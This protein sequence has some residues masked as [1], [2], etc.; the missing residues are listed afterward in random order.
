VA[1]GKAIEIIMTENKNNSLSEKWPTERSRVRATQ[2]AFDASEAMDICI[3]KAA[4]ER[5]ISPSDVIREIIGLKVNK[6]V[7]RKRLT[8]SLSEDDYQLL[9]KKYALNRVNKSLVK[10][11]VY[12]ELQDYAELKS[13][14][15][16]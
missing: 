12:E 7:K 11:L 14:I 13:N 9:A 10:Q 5:G 3:R 6:G 1:S 4:Y 8:V 16:T 2:V 15:K